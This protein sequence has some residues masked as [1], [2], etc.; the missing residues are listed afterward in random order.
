MEKRLVLTQKTWLVVIRRIRRGFLGQWIQNNDQCSGRILHP[1][2]ATLW[3]LTLLGCGSSEMQPMQQAEFSASHE[4]GSVRPGFQDATALPE[5]ASSANNQTP[6]TGNSQTNVADVRKIIYTTK[7]E[8]TVADLLA[9]SAGLKAMVEKNQGYVASEQTDLNDRQFPTGTWV[10][11]IPIQNYSDFLASAGSLG[12]LNHQSSTTKE[13]T[14]EFVDMQARIVNAKRLEERILKLLER[15]SDRLAEVIEVENELSRVR[16]IIERL[17]GRLRYLSDATDLTTITISADQE[18]D[19]LPATAAT[20]S[21]RIRMRWEYSLTVTTNYVQIFV[22]IIVG[23]FP[24]AL[25][26]A[27]LSPLFWAVYLLRRRLLG[28]GIVE[29]TQRNG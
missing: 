4:A 27:M 29:S 3:I 26:L 23:L 21:Q 7:L 6:V 10:V 12:C 13:I 28:V 14:D 16:E 8:F 25:V 15:S 17:E 24:S 20:F 18:K 11:R 19:Y 1:T 5:K 9:T 2:L 22:L